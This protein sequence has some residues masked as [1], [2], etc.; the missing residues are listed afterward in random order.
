MSR[1]NVS[2]RGVQQ[3]KRSSKRPLAGVPGVC[4]GS[5]PADGRPLGVP[6]EAANKTFTGTVG[7]WSTPRSGTPPSFPPNLDTIFLTFNGATSPDHL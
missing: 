6:A 2:G 3:I 4:G 7:N 1:V 5:P